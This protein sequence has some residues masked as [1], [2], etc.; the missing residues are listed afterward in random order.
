M[1][2][3]E[4]PKKIFSGVNKLLNK[5]T[6]SIFSG[7]LLGLAASTGISNQA[8]AIDLAQ[9]EEWNDTT[10]SGTDVANNA[11]AGTA[12]NIVIST[13]TIDDTGDSVAIGDVT[14]STGEL[15]YTSDAAETDIANT[16]NSINLTGA[17]NI[18]INGLNADDATVTITITD[19][20][21]TAGYLKLTSTEA[22]N[23]DTITL[24]IGGNVAVTA[25]SVFTAAAGASSNAHVNVNFA[26]AT[27]TFTA[28][29]NMDDNGGI[30][31]INVDGTT[32]QTI[33][34]VID[35]VGANEGTLNVSQTSGTVTF[36]DTIGAATATALL[37]IE[38]DASA[39]AK[40]SSK[41]LVKDFNVDG[42]LWF[43]ENANEA[44]N[45]LD[46]AT[47]SKIVVDDTISA[48]E[49]VLDVAANATVVAGAMTVEMPSNFTSGTITLL[50]TGHDI[51]ADIANITVTD[52]ALHNYSIA[53]AN[54]DLDAH[55]TVAEYSNADVKS[56]LS[57][58]HLN[59]AKAL[60]QAALAFRSETA[61]T[62]DN[63]TKYLNSSQSDSSIKELAQE[64]GTQADVVQG[65]MQAA[66]VANQNTLTINSQRLASLR[67][68]TNF[69]TGGATGFNA[70]AGTSSHS[71]FLRVFANTVSQDMAGGVNGYDSDLTGV[72]IGFDGEAPNGA[73]G[74]IS[75]TQAD[76]DIDGKGTGQA[77][78]DV[79]SHI[80]SFYTDYSTDTY[81]VEGQLALGLNQYTSSRKVNVSNLS[82]DRTIK[83]DFNG[84]QASLSF[85]VGKPLP[86]E[87]GWWVTPRLDLTLLK[88]ATGS[89]TESGGT[90]LNQKYDRSTNNKAIAGFGFN[91]DNVKET[92]ASTVNT[93]LRFGV[94]YDLLDDPIKMTAKFV[95][96][97]VEYESVVNQ[98]AFSAN[99]GLGLAA[100]FGTFELGL[101][102]DSQFKDNYEGY[103]G[104][105]SA[106]YKF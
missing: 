4:Q 12:V 63:T 53:G 57:L 58:N 60:K 78:S 32:D 106:R 8:R 40:F 88:T 50:D 61:T 9:A 24:D 31:T 6:I 27:V 26:G 69:P 87:K 85:A 77:K 66:N 92:D 35:G 82:I 95:D 101:D 93:Q 18:D 64:G 105:I 52:T 3:G 10:A 90:N 7:A 20:L 83:G 51:S 34:G 33:N 89:Y 47:G 71:V 70:G 17:G 22:D 49:D 62:L 46:W 48:G 1:R 97:G 21:T 99:I 75:Y 94:N 42:T 84:G 81:Y 14:G 55:I 72:T 11:S 13:L 102:V 79:T 19:Q 29:F 25:D 104:L 80:V 59:E 16:T 67:D 15:I 96:T 38:I 65:Q 23:A 28:G 45:G 2:E 56:N 39:V 30:V 76:T 100:A 41:I 91:I 5:K 68:G 103:T 54:S 44:R 98:E 37:E 73:R 74:G 36:A 43:G 86:Q